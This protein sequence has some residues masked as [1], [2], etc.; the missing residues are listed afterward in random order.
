MHELSIV[1][2]VVDAVIEKLDSYPG[3]RVTEV[4][5]RV[6]ALAAVVEDSLQFC[7]E[8]ATRETPLEGSQLV[9]KL[10]PVSVHCA[11][12][13]KDGELESL[14]SFRCR[15]CGE[16]A[17]DVRQ[18]REMEIEAFEIEDAELNAVEANDFDARAS[19]REETVR[20]KS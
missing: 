9:V 5:L 17:S 18:G 13:G 11:A 10:V 6:G 20:E 12:C 16:P 19:R 2:S 4:R 14:Q 8:L 1:A 3:A 15:H 7:Y